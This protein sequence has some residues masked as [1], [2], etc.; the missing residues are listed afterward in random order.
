M[1]GKSDNPSFSVGLEQAP[2]SQQDRI[3]LL[4]ERRQIDNI[5][6]EETKKR[7]LVDNLRQKAEDSLKRLQTLESERDKIN[8][9]TDEENSKQQKIVANKTILKRL[10]TRLVHLNN[11]FETYNF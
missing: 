11:F 8:T 4:R 3:K 5:L 10:D 1:D 7:S 6:E 9:P 2:F